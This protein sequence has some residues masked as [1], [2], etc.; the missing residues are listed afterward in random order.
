MTQVRC[1]RV[2]T[3][4][5]SERACAT[6]FVLAS[7]LTRRPRADGVGVSWTPHELARYSV[8]HQC[9]DGYERSMRLRIDP[10][11]RLRATH[12]DR[13][14]RKRI[15]PADDEEIDTAA[16]DA[17]PERFLASREIRDRWLALARGIVERSESLG[18]VLTPDV[19]AA[20]RA[21]Q[22]AIG[23][24]AGTAKGA[25]TRLDKRRRA[26][27]ANAVARIIAAA[28]LGEG[29][30]WSR[31]REREAARP[32]ALGASWWL[33][34]SERIERVRALAAARS[35]GLLPPAA[36]EIAREKR[37]VVR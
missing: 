32:E 11:M 25:A 24:A 23:R 34:H 13:G 2:E 1:S 10:E 33:R 26:K 22:E 28:T 20:E 12:R 3:C 27:V 16:V 9:P 37:R 17:S 4:V 31:R 15:G 30:L 7:H 14:F 35:V 5:L 8:C 19:I 6:R 18:P 21:A 36:L 29:T